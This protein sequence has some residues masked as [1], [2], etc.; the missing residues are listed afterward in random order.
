M[1]RRQ[2]DALAVVLSTFAE[3]P[4]AFAAVGSTVGSPIGSLGLFLTGYFLILVVPGPNMV[5]IFAVASTHGLYRAVPMVAA[6]G[7]GSTTLLVVMA[8]GASTG[9]A[10]DRVCAV[11]AVASG[12]LLLYAAWRLL[13]LAPPSAVCREQAKPVASAIKDGRVGFGCSLTN[14]VT[15]AYFL[16]A[17]LN[18][19][20]PWFRGPQ[21]AVTCAAVLVLAMAVNLLVARLLSLKAA[22][23]AARRVFWPLKI[24]AA[25]MVIAL[26]AHALYPYLGP[27][28]QMLTG[29]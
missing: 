21:L 16:S 24:G 10:Q 13:H 5:V 18:P 8:M 15:A 25:G 23:D 22:Q 17:I 19:D 4:R 11:L 1:E 12:M 9:L 26:G 29:W 2:M 3:L 14:P 7:A 20:N 28:R 27:V 6:I